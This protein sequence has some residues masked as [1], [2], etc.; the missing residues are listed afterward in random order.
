MEEISALLLIW[1]I[2]TGIAAVLSAPVIYF[3]RKRVH[4]RSWELL[5]FVLPFLIWTCLMFSDLAT[6]EKSL[7]NL[8]EPFVFAL[9]IPIAALLRVVF[10]KSVS[11]P[12]CSG[13]L[14]LLVCLAAITV[15]FT[16]PSLPE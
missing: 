4:W 2:H 12:L 3:G 6:G 16:V 1:S 10:A 11:E 8:G 5:T 7:S 15:F 13:I 14:I 9:A